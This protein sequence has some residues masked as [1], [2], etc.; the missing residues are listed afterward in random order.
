LTTDDV[1]VLL[2]GGRRVPR[3]LAG[4]AAGSAASAAQIDA[5]IGTCRR[6]I[7][8][9]C[10]ADLAAVLTRLL[11]TDRL[12]VEVGYAPR[13]RSSATRAYRLRSGWLGARRAGSGVAQRVPLIRDEAGVVL[14]GA[15]FWL[16]EAD[17]A[18][19]RVYG[20]AVVDDTTLFDGGA[21]G[22]RIEPTLAAPGL[23]AG[24][25]PGHLRPGRWVSG[26]AAQLGTTGAR[27]VRDGVPAARP[28]RRSTFYRH[29]EG[30]L[31]VR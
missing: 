22:V 25:L 7:V 11:R 24:L 14:A 20:E 6:V 2:F 3:G 5:A 4:S 27:V 17:A 12:D 10:D 16:P 29:I 8:A 9:G 19:G 18:G 26:R 15:A 30:W 21:T 23:R 28:V 1:I 31:L 13:R